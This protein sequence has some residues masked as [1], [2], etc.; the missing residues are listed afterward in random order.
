MHVSL[1]WSISFVFTEIKCLIFFLLDFW[2]F[3][4]YFEFLINFL[5]SFVR[6]MWSNLFKIIA[7]SVVSVKPPLLLM[8]VAQPREEA[9]N[10]VRPKGSS[11][12]DGT[13]AISDLFNKSKIFLW[14]KKPSSICLSWWIK[15]FLLS[16]SPA[17]NAFHLGKLS[18]IFFIDFSKI[19]YPFE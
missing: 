11:H 6:L 12:L 13:T 5:I 3:F 2:I 9:S 4:L 8:I 15:I 18:K 14:F 19:S 1:I 7:S 16:S 17:E 10:A